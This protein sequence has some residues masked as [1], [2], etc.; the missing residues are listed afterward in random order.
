MKKPTK[1]SIQKATERVKKRMTLAQMRLI[2]KYK[3]L[4]QEGYDLLV[5]NAEIFAILILQAYIA[6]NNSNIPS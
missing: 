3:D 1:D 4:T 5:K 6:V 2:P